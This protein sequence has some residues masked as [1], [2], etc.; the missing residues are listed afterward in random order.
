MVAHLTKLLPVPAL[1]YVT[2]SITKPPLSP[3][4]LIGHKD[5]S[6]GG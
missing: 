3:A 6:H 1:L 5:N 4:V 2:V